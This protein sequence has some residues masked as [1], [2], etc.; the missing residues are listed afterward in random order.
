VRFQE[1]YR[2]FNI[3]ELQNVASEAASSGP[4]IRLEKMREDLDDKT[5]KLTMAGG[6]TLIARIPYRNF[7]AP[8]LATASKVATLEFVSDVCQVHKT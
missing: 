3:R 5:F 7:G 1:R 4:C 6:K 8:S 2:V